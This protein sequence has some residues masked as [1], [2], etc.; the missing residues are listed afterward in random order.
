MQLHAFEA[1][2]TGEQGVEVPLLRPALGLLAPAGLVGLPEVLLPLPVG[3]PAGDLVGEVDAGLRAEAELVGGLVEPV[4]GVL[5]R[6]EPAVLLPLVVRELVEDGVAGDLE[7]PAQADR[8][9]ALRLEVLED[10]AADAVRGAAGVA[11]VEGV[12][13]VDGGGGRHHLE[14]RAGGGLRLDGPVQ[15]RVVGTLAG[16]PLVVL[17]VDPADPGVGVVVGVG[18]HRHHAPRL[19]LHH[20]D[21]ARVRLVRAVGVA[22]DL[23]AGVL[24]GLRQLFLRQ[25]LHTG[26]DAGDDAGAGLALLALGLADDPAEVVDLVAGDAGLA[27]QIAVVRPLKTGPA[28]LVGAQQRR[29]AVLGLGDLLVGDRGEIA[30]DLG[31]VGAAGG[32]VAADCGG[33]GADAG[34]VLGA[35]A[36]LEGLLGGGLVRDRDGLVG[37]AVPAGLRGLGV[38]EPG[39]VADLLLRHAENL[40]EPAEHGLAVVLHLQQVGTAG[41]DDQTGLV[42][43]QRHTARI[44]DRAAGGGFD[45]LLNV[46]ALGLV[47]VLLA[48]A[49]LQ[50]PEPAA[51]GE[52]KGEDQDLDR[53]QA[54]RDARGPARLG[55]V[56]HSAPTV[57]AMAGGCARR[58]VL[59]RG[60]T[61]VRPAARGSSPLTA[62][63]PPCAPPCRGRSC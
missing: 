14:D 49:D 1:A 32:G 48:V 24:H 37:G 10:L 17:G 59:G 56:A 16:E 55:K 44:E 58:P 62:A 19:R 43:G 45:D 33:L 47:G 51:E 54:D 60:A 38:A 12:A 50:I 41:G 20:H 35:L 27:A 13:G 34:E 31:G 61:Q 28:D 57:G 7:R 30:E 52:Q 21:G 29:V 25:R 46:V 23:L 63:C 42:V 40:G 8:A 22:V 11:A 53:D 26:I 18:G 3:H 5:L 6:L 2:L 39:L 15:Q 4:L 9:V 36:D